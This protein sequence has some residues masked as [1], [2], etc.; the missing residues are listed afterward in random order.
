MQATQDEG[1][2]HRSHSLSS[3]SSDTSGVAISIEDKLE[4]VLCSAQDVGFY[5]FDDAVASYYVA[6]LDEMSPMSLQQRHSRNRR[7]PSVLAALQQ[8]VD[9]WTAWEKRGYLDEVMISAEGILESELRTFVGSRLFRDLVR[10]INRS[11]LA[12]TRCGSPEHDEEVEALSRLRRSISAELPN[13]WATL[14][15]L[16]SADSVPDRPA[17]AQLALACSI[18]VCLSGHICPDALKASVDSCLDGELDD[19]AGQLDSA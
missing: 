11:R 10:T 14:S 4:H 3:E 16:A 17:G 8:N 5:D 7:L 2:A 9:T 6:E 12:G 18:L 1:P 13:L 15:A 19:D